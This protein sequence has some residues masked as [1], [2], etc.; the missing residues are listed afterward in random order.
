MYIYVTG[1]EKSSLIYSKFTCSYYSI[2]ISPILYICTVANLYILLDFLW[3]TAY[4]AYK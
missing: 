4:Q 2:Y 3:N 1:P